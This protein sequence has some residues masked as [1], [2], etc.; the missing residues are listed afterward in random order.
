[1]AMYGD[2]A[3]AVTVWGPGMY[4]LRPGTGQSKVTAPAGQEPKPAA[5]Q[6]VAENSTALQPILGHW[7]G[8]LQTGRGDLEIIVDFWTDEV[9]FHGS[10]TVHRFDS[11]RTLAGIRFESPK[12]HFEDGEGGIYE[13]ELEG[14]TISGMADISGRSAPFSL[15][16]TADGREP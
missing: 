8:V 12:V 14:D 10:L 6:A 15:K 9:G 7:E 16:R 5:K 1:M 4:I 3:V 2:Y 11:S 13:G